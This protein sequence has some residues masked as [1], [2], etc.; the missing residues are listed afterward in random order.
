M[1]FVQPTHAEAPVPADRF[2]PVQLAQTTPSSAISAT[3][4]DAIHQ[5]VSGYYDAFARDSAAAAA[6]Y[7][8]PTLIVLPNQVIILATRPD[9][10]AFLAKSLASLKPLGYSYS[11][12]VDPR[13]KLLNATTSIYSTIAV[14]SKADG[15]EM[16]RAGFTY[17][18]QKDN[19]GWKIR[20]LIAT[21]LDKL[22]NA[23]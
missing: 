13:T 7:G 8:E 18:L 22:V 11:K 12:V 6:F 2:V 10:E 4:K 21:D 3:E 20:G 23:D 14:R 15:T 5:V 17:L 19:S 9:V 16:Q 1:F